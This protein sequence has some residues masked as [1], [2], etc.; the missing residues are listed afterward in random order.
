MGKEEAIESARRAAEHD[1]GRTY[2]AYELE[3]KYGW[4]AKRPGMSG[5]IVARFRVDAED[6]RV[7]VSM[8]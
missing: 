2:V 3:G 5:D 6:R 1:K 7:V 4:C 8:T